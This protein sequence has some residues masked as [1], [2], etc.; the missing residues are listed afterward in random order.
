M[1]RITSTLREN[2]FT[3]TTIYPGILFGMKNVSGKILEKIKTYFM[4]NNFFSKI[5]PFLRLLKNMVDPDR[6]QMRI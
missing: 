6:P 2:V 4:F 1:T 5:V 3:R